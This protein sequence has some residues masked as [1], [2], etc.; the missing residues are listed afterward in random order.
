MQ[1]SS[2][3]CH[4]RKVPQEVRSLASTQTP[5]ATSKG[6]A[7]DQHVELLVQR[8]HMDV[9]QL[10]LERAA[11]LSNSPSKGVHLHTDAAPLNA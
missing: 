2:A 11:E 3:A 6:G 1:L 4:C 7:Q 5:H 8:T 10:A 9:F